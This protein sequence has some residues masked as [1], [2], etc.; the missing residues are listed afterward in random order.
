LAVGKIEK[1]GFWLFQSTVESGC[2]QGCTLSINRRIWVH[3]GVHAFNQQL[4][5]MLQS[6]YRHTMGFSRIEQQNGANNRWGITVM[7]GR[8]GLW[9]LYLARN[10]HN[11]E[12]SITIEDAL[13]SKQLLHERIPVETEPLGKMLGAAGVEAAK[14]NRVMQIK[15]TEDGYPYLI[16]VPGRMASL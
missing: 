8:H 14:I 16:D 11:H 1:S 4:N 9:T 10:Q 15:R 12:L 13:G 6:T 7:Q 5:W 2:T 3:T